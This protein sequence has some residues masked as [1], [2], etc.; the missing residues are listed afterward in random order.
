[1]KTIEKILKI[2][3]LNRRIELLKEY[4]RKERNIFSK[5]KYQQG[6]DELLTE[7]EKYLK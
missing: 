5:M 7:S 4:K 6:I 2:V 3:D 1:M